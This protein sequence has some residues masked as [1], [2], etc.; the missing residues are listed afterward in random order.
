FDPGDDGVDRRR[1]EP[2]GRRPLD[3]GT[4]L[5]PVERLEG[6]RPFAH[7]Q[8]DVFDALVGGVPPPARETFAPAPNRRAFVG[9]ARVDDLVVVRTAEG[10]A[11]VF[12]V[13][14]V[15]CRNVGVPHARVGSAVV[16]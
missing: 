10:T 13:A 12:T 4:Q 7:L 11:H 1:V 5:G 9:H 15:L 8:A 14:S 6:A 3:A 16:Q 2:V